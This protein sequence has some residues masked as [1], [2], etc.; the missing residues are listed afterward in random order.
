MPFPIIFQVVA[1]SFL[2]ILLISI[3]IFAPAMLNHV[4]QNHWFYITLM[5]LAFSLFLAMSYIENDELILDMRELCLYEVLMYGVG[6]TLFLSKI[7]PTTTMTGLLSTAFFLRFGRLLWVFKNKE[8]GRFVA[9]PVFGVL[10]WYAK[11]QRCAETASPVTPTR[12]Q[13]WGA[14]FFIALCFTAGFIIPMLGI[15]LAV[16]HVGLI[17]F[18]VTPFIARR[19]LAD[20][21]RQNIIYETTLNAKIKAEGIAEEKVRSNAVLEAKN[22][23]L[24]LAKAQ[25]E[26]AREEAIQAKT[27]AEQ[28]HA[29]IA[30]LL[31]E[32]EKD[33]ATLEKFNA[34]L[35]DAAHDLQHPMAVV[36]IFG[37]A[38]IELEE[39]E[40]RDPVTRQN[41]AQ[42]LTMAMEEMVDMI[43][44]TIHSAQVVTGI[45][46]P[47][48]RVIDMNALVKEFESQWFDGPNR[49]GLDRLI[50]YPRRKIKLFAVC[51]LL[52]L[53]RILR[54]LI[55]N[56]IQHSGADGRVLLVLRR[57]GE[58]CLVQVRDSG[59]GIEE[60]FSGDKVANF[61]AFTQRIHKE[62]SQVKEAGKRGGYRL[63]MHNVL[64]LCKATELTMQ[65]C[66]K[67]ERGS[68]F[69]FML[70]LATAEQCLD[71]RQFNV[72]KE[73]ELDEI[74]AL[75]E[76]RNDI[77]MPIGE[78]FPKDDDRYSPDQSRSNLASGEVSTPVK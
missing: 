73:R 50:T 12:W 18:L 77:P 31:I 46:K 49:A 26:R 54:N 40:V 44:A 39:Q 30:Q 63:G 14:Y 70:P 48:L 41:I 4:A 17:T 16:A 62:G 15:K 68:M 47:A 66:A 57:V 10:G 8:S 2:W 22:L 43:D 72:E 23:E 27:E 36:R 25:A 42:K 20:M 33:K 75:M 65:L 19:I 9:W 55:A 59:H 71:T 52:I 61:A 38:L 6:L 5:L 64:Q 56:A 37:N 53:K 58:H 7:D 76:A 74:I 3:E 29:E 11:H 21:K 28:A 69:A 32:R 13:A 51:D 35:R 24:E 67:P 60:G 1:R 34:A 78:F 45:I